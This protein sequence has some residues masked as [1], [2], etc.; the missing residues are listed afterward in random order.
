[1]S[2]KRKIMALSVSALLTVFSTTASAAVDMFIK[3]GDVEGESQHADHRGAIDVLAW[4]WG[5]SSEGQ[6]NNRG[7]ACVDG[8]SLTK[9]IDKASGELMMSV[10]ANQSFPEATLTITRQGERPIDYL[11]ITLRNVSVSS[12]STG[13]SSGQDR[14]TESVTLNFEVAEWVYTEQRPDGRPGSSS[15]STIYGNCR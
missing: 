6:R 12:V 15:T 10:V 8:L 4:S 14:L 5:V 3:I 7:G 9:W 2:I 11:T 13:G 1:M